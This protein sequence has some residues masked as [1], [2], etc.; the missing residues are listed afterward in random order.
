V[1][2]CRVNERAQFPRHRASLGFEARTACEIRERAVE[3]LTFQTTVE[4]LTFQ[5]TVVQ[6]T[7]QTTAEQLT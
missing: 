5:T 4:Q 3:Q 1:W 7:F 2:H 6:L